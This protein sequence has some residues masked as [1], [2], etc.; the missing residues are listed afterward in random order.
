MLFLEQEEFLLVQALCALRPDKISKATLQKI[1]SKADLYIGNIKR[2]NLF[3]LDNQKDT[4][5]FIDLL[6]GISI[7]YMPLVMRALKNSEAKF[8]AC[9]IQS[10]YVWGNLSNITTH[11]ERFQENDSTIYKSLEFFTLYIYQL[12][13][14]VS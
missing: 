4:D 13:E 7:Q 8:W 2:S 3:S 11:P 6:F 12:I 14:R 1:Q 5:I 9:Q 10:L